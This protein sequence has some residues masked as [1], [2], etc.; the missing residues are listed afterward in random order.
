MVGAFVAINS[1]VLSLAVNVSGPATADTDV[2]RYIL[3]AA[4]I[5]ILGLLGPPL[6]RSSV[7]E[8]RHGKITIELLFLLG[9]AGALGTS[10]LSQFTGSGPVYYEVASILVVVYT[11]GRHLTAQVQN[12]ALGLLAESL[13]GIDSCELIDDSGFARE[14]RVEDI[15]IGQRVRVHPGRVIPVDGTVRVGAALVQESP[16]TGEFFTV[17]KKI[18]DKTLAG[19]HVVDSTLII[20]SD[21]EGRQR[22]IDSIQELLARAQACPSRSQK[23]VSVLAA[24]FVPVVCGTALITFAAW[25]RVA[26][27]EV[28][29]FN[30][31]SVLL[32]ACPCALGFAAPVAVWA[33]LVRLSG[34]GIVL[35]NSSA[36]EK[37]AD[38]GVVIFDKTGTLTEPDL[39]NVHLELVP[40][41]KVT[42]EQAFACLIATEM[43]SDHPIA[44]AIA[45]AITSLAP[46]RFINGDA[47]HLRVLPGVGLEA[48]I[49]FRTDEIPHAIR[50]GLL[51][52]LNP[53]SRSVADRVLGLDVDGIATATVHLEERQ[54]NG[55][56]AAV[57]SF[58]GLGIRTVLLTGDIAARAGRIPI[59]E[60]TSEALPE[61]KLAFVRA[62]QDRG[63]SVLFIG[64]GLNDAAAMAA[65]DVSLAPHPAC[66][67]AEAVAD[68]IWRD[69]SFASLIQAI[70]IS[71]IAV[72]TIRS[73]FWI[74]AGYN[75]I[76][77]A[78]AALGLLHPVSA[79]LLMTASSITVT[80]RA[81]RLLESATSTV[82][83]RLPAEV[84]S[85]SAA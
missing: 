24:W 28:A 56:Q 10:M 77:M 15:R 40:G 79:V 25:W 29:L 20:E 78:L 11:L 51:P 12:K 50:I 16:L 73:N 37:L 6:L 69:R 31:L 8:L 44:K 47:R 80:W 23:L 68:G 41:A 26:P 32:V 5:A 72:R 1:M 59:A 36:V 57:E 42:L 30:A 64:D 33:T 61:A 27:T 7:G 48:E 34:S 67:V 82:A 3:L 38:A 17:A 52:W 75:S 83:T 4:T 22:R 46:V 76:G 53:N 60:Q 81:L 39:A 18:G 74:A 19:S 43:A 21:R 58:A 13:P 45:K 14:V 65:S 71:R 63:R 55:I 70:K 62:E 66:G 54:L 84:E 49:R 35:K 85:E 9:I 2:V